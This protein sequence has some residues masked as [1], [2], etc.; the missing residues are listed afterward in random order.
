MDEKHKKGLTGIIVSSGLLTKKQMEAVLAK[1]EVFRARIIKAR[2]MSIKKS[3]QRPDVSL[4][5]I[6]ESSN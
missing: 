2:G 4:L 5:E 1:E 3:W 6:I